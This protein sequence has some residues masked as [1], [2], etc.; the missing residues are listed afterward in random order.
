MV[1]RVLEMTGAM[2]QA[3]GEIY[4]EVDQSVILYGNESWVLTREMIKV[5]E[6]FHHQAARRIT[7]MIVKRGSGGEWK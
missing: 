6:G 7:G 4:R 1:V 5:L 2:V 3:Q